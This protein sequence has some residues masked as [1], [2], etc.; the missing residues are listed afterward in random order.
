MSDLGERHFEMI[1]ET[2]SRSFKKEINISLV[3]FDTALHVTHI[4]IEKYKDHA[5]GVL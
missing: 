1:G 4:E 3:V 2:L 5:N